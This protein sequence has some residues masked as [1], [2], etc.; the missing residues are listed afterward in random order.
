MALSLEDQPS[1]DD[2]NPSLLQNPKVALSVGIAQWGLEYRRHS[3]FGWFNAILILNGSIFIIVS[4]KIATIC[5]LFN[6]FY[7]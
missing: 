1:Y 7:W 2:L 4:N 5:S 3:N 6:L